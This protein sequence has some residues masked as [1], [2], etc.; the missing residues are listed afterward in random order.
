MAKFSNSTCGQ[1]DRG[2]SYVA[3]MRCTTD[4][5]PTE[6]KTKQKESFNEYCVGL[7]RESWS[8]VQCTRLIA[9]CPMPKMWRMFWN[10][11]M[12][13]III[14]IVAVIYMYMY[15]ILLSYSI[16]LH[17]RYWCKNW[18]PLTQVSL[19]AWKWQ[20][21]FSDTQL[22]YFCMI[23]SISLYMYDR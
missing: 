22:S 9:A 19:R 7:C 2:W 4:R 1:E 12:V 15:I 17:T 21:R 5:A 13:K 11:N 8:I 14:K 3:D 20:S 6:P 10:C 23:V 16:K 18:L